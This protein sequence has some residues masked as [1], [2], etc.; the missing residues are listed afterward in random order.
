MHEFI[1]ATV[2]IATNT[3]L[4]FRRRTRAVYMNSEQV[5]PAKF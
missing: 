5:R 1:A 4:N 2:M 3:A